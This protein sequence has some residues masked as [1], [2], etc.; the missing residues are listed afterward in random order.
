MLTSVLMVVLREPDIFSSG[1]Q[2][3]KS[4]KHWIALDEIVLCGNMYSFDTDRR[5]AESRLRTTSKLLEPFRKK[6][7]FLVPKCV[8]YSVLG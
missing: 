8:S 7:C 6:L 3:K 5:V 4:E 1:T 2:C